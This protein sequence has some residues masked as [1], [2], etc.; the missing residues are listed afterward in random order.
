MTSPDPRHAL[1]SG[2][3]D[4]PTL[5]HLDLARRGLAAFARLTIAVGSHPT[6]AGLFTPAERIAQFRAALTPEELE[7][8]D[9]VEFD[10]LVIE[11]CRTAGAAI[12]LRGLRSGSDFDYEAQMAAT[13]RAM[14]P[15]LDTL[16][17]A[18]SPH[19]AH[20][21][22]TLAR[23]IASMGG[24]VSSLVPSSVQDAIR[25]SQQA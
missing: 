13:N 1:F 24:D 21:S 15:E 18:A 2:S 7:R 19:V 11:A 3:F 10:G 14:A 4:P 22:S 5:G 12:I 9:F 25:A 8:C 20:I 16:F 23:Q 6:K 17:F